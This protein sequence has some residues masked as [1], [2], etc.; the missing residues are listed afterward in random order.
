MGNNLFPMELIVQVII[1]WIIKANTN[2]KDSQVR[3][4]FGHKMICIAPFQNSLKN[5][6]VPQTD[7]PG[8]DSQ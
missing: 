8:F 3:S 6:K 5:Y 2:T 7:R 1:F 4:D